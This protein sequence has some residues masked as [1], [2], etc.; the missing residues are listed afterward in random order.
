M[1]NKSQLHH[2]QIHKASHS[3][4]FPSLRRSFARSHVAGRIP[5][6][7]PTSKGFAKPRRSRESH[8][9]P[10][11]RRRTR[12]A[13]SPPATF[14]SGMASRSESCRHERVFEVPLSPNRIPAGSGGLQGL[15]HSAR[16]RQAR[17]TSLQKLPRPQPARI[18]PP[19]RKAPARRAAY[20]QNFPSYRKG[21]DF[22]LGDNEHETRNPLYYKG[23]KQD[24]STA[25]ARFSTYLGLQ[26][27][28]KG[29]YP[30]PRSSDFLRL[31]KPAH[32]TI[33]QSHSIC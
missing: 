1:E 2:S 26:W 20:P 33:A 30:P 8:L 12:N 4:A 28:F 3:L 32:E 19:P 21:V 31:W 16:R 7:M 23:S 5:S 14:S 17:K 11:L 29:K 27:D 18:H 6:R 24:L 13:E 9:E 22:V 15:G 25:R 10:G